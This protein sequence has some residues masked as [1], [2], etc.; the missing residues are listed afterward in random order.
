MIIQCLFRTYFNWIIWTLILYLPGGQSLVLQSSVYVDKPSHFP[1]KAS[2]T[3]FFLVLVWV[4]PPHVLEHLPYI[5]PAHS[6]ST[7][8]TKRIVWYWPTSF[9][10][11][12]LNQCLFRTYL[13][14]LYEHLFTIYLA[15]NHQGCNPPFLLRNRQ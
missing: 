6:Q 14:E 5:Q 4:P 11:S 13:I 1:P 3:F 8:H 2:S 15:D 12:V 7:E 9:R 10:T